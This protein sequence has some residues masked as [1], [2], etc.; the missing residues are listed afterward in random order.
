[1]RGE[2]YSLLG[3]VYYFALLPPTTYRRSHSHVD[4]TGD[5]QPSGS[6]SCTNVG[7]TYTMTSGTGNC[8]VIANQPSDS[9]CLPTPPLPVPLSPTRVSQA[10]TVTVPA[11]PTANNKSS[12][13]GIPSRLG[14][15]SPAFPRWHCVKEEMLAGFSGPT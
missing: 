9:D 11:P 1:M 13:Y 14:K 8:L 7:W 10:I 12:L 3:L 15:T 5:F 2:K 4:V 6:G